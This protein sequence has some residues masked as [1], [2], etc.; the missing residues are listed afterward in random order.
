ME[1]HN[2]N[3]HDE[4]E[5]STSSK[6]EAANEPVLDEVPDDNIDSI[7]EHMYNPF[8]ASSDG[9]ESVV[10]VRENSLVDRIYPFA[11]NRPICEC[12]TVRRMT[13]S[14]DVRY[15]L[16]LLPDMAEMNETQKSVFRNR[17]VALLNDTFST[18]SENKPLNC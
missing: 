16:S 3:K 6:N 15:L 8:G 11:D 5:K 1:P 7:S 9:P 18:E 2:G 12:D 13:S 14:P 4:S 17:V 10:D